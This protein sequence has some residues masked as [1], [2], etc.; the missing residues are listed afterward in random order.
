MN[1]S[2]QIIEALWEVKFKSMD[3]AA[4]YNGFIKLFPGALPPVGIGPG[5][6]TLRVASKTDSA[7]RG[8]DK[9]AIAVTRMPLPSMSNQGPQPIT[10]TFS[11]TTFANTEELDGVFL[12]ELV[13]VFTLFNGQHDDHG[14]N[15]KRV[16]AAVS[17]KWGHTVPGE[18][19][20]LTPATTRGLVLMLKDGLPV[21]IAMVPAKALD[22]KFFVGSLLGWFRS[23]DASRLR[24]MLFKTKNPLTAHLKVQKASNSKGIKFARVKHPDDVGDLMDQG[25]HGTGG[26][27]KELALG[28]VPPEWL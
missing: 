10:V 18:H 12:H 4:K 16:A 17:K 9:R 23:K 27:V 8:V 24:F 26:F 7:F 3:L 14:P 25:T 1:Q 20:Q 2:Q 6:V 13:H 5:K 11:G 22:D 28:D 21:G 15:F 19:S